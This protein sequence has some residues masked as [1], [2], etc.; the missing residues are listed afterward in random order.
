MNYSF[1]DIFKDEELSDDTRDYLLADFDPLD[2]QEIK[3]VQ[4]FRE[5]G[6]KFDFTLV[7]VDVYDGVEE[8][9]IIVEKYEKTLQPGAIDN[10]F[11]RLYNHRVYVTVIRRS[12]KIIGFD[13]S[14][15]PE[16]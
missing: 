4:F 2:E 10:D 3:T 15:I 16:D 12:G 9:A 13:E 5:Q 1:P 11:S 6:K 7:G 14:A 8:D